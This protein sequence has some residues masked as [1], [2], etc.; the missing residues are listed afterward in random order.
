[1]LSSV[2]S[3]TL[4]GRKCLFPGSLR[5]HERTSSRIP[6]PFAQNSEVHTNNYCFTLRIAFLG[7]ERIVLRALDDALALFSS[8]DYPRHPSFRV[9]PVTGNASSHK[10]LF[11]NKFQIMNTPRFS[12]TTKASEALWTL[13]SRTSAKFRLSSTA[14]MCSLTRLVSL[15]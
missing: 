7:P 12:S 6:I 5:R 10:A 3:C 13:Q 14:Q 4:H 8:G 9:H 1:M 2:P 15:V 11:H